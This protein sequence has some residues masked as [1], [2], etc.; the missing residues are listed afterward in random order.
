[1][2]KTTTYILAFTFVLA[3][4]VSC[5]KTSRGK[6]SNEWKIS[7][8]EDK[9]SYTSGT[10]KIDYSE[11][12][13]DAS[14]Q[15]TTTQ[16]SNSSIVEGKISTNDITINKDG[17]WSGASEMDY[18]VTN[19]GDFGA[20]S[21]TKTIV[22]ES[23]SGTWSFIGKNKTEEFKKNEKVIFNILSLDK[24]ETAISVVS[25]PG[26]TETSSWTTTN[27]ESLTYNSGQVNM[28]FHIDESSR[29][30]LKLSTDDKTTWNNKETWSSGGISGTESYSGSQSGFTRMTL[31]KK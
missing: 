4:I 3:T 10:L 27:S 5:G 19:D 15:R 11:I 13:T 22:K 16:G 2:K 7:S 30:E 23:R 14:F 17:T 18:T 31:T 25:F 6:I 21:T 9:S 29:K 26:T 1:M 28:I 24:T 12:G 20:T 8:Y